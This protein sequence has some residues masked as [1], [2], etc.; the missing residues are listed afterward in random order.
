LFGRIWRDGGF[1]RENG[2]QL[3]HQPRVHEA[4]KNL[5]QTLERMQER[6][7]A[8]KSFGDN[9][10]VNRP[11]ETDERKQVASEPSVMKFRVLS[12]E[13]REEDAR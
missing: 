10:A 3:W 2:I 12:A 8:E 11:K 6:R 9:E 5:S 1:R 7:T 13:N 4:V